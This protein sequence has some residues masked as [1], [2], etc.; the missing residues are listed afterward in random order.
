MT[1]TA[2]ANNKMYIKD[3][4]SP[5]GGVSPIMIASQASFKTSLTDMQRVAIPSQ[6][7]WGL[8]I[9]SRKRDCV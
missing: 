8:N 7:A 5:L 1:L 9:K 4:I 3:I 6:A 2:S